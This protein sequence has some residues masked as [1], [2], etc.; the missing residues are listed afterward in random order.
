MTAPVY[1]ADPPEARRLIA[2][3]GLT[4]VFHRPSGLT[5]FL[6][7]PA[8]EILAAL[9]DGE[10]DAET[11]LARLRRNHELDESVDLAGPLAARLAELETAGL[12][13]RS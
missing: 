11:L 5:H 6:G 12:V 7:S 2:L 4:L 10:A 9:A 13:W 1:R 8:P 3:D